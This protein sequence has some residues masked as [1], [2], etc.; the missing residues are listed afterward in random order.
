ML[1]SY[2]LELARR[3][4]RAGETSA[5]AECQAMRQQPVH[6]HVLATNLVK[7]AFVLTPC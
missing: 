4:T 3:A 6:G 1:R 5:A 7:S 2:C